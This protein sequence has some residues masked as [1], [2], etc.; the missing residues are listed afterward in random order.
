[1][2]E[3]LFTFSRHRTNYFSWISHSMGSLEV[4][5]GFCT[6]WN[7]SHGS[8][9]LCVWAVTCQFTEQFQESNSTFISS[10]ELVNDTQEEYSLSRTHQ[11]PECLQESPRWCIFPPALRAQNTWPLPTSGNTGGGSQ[12]LANPFSVN[13]DLLSYNTLSSD[14]MFGL[15]FQLTLQDWGVFHQ[16]RTNQCPEA[17]VFKVWRL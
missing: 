11:W 16:L 10:V 4:I 7:K 14:Q 8:P 15:S 9:L 1:M 6:P 5:N 12:R 17:Y 3:K 13:Y 2:N